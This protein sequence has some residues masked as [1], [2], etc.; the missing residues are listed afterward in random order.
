MTT[1]IQI[2]RTK[3]EPG[4]TT[5]A[6]EAPVEVVRKAERKAASYYAKRVRLPGF[7]KGKVP[8]DVVRRRFGDA[9]KETVIKELVT[10]SW[11]IALDREKLE[12]IAE[13]QV[14]ELK[15]EEN[16]PV[17][18]EFLVEVKPDLAIDRVGGF[19]VT[20]KVP[21][22]TEEMVEAQIEELRRQNAPLIPI[23]N[24]K[25]E[26]G[27]YVQ[28]TLAMLEGGEDTEGKP[29]H[30]QLGAG[31]AI[32]APQG[33]R[34]GQS[35]R[36]THPFHAGHNPAHTCKGGPR[37]SEISNIINACVREKYE[38]KNPHPPTIEEHRQIKLTVL[39]E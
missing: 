20:R 36:V 11:K 23:E 25:P 16:Q 17:T 1:E 18:F 9:I 34:A 22:V 29:Y 21:P 4:A 31:Q 30:L 15:F 19:S 13:P 7:R 35:T 28:V 39:E 6:V 14:H 12:P 26:P 10:D 27:D 32:P 24:A 37:L 2:T 38:A 5:L 8:P 33:S 3:D